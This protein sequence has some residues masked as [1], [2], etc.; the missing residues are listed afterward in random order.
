MEDFNE[1]LARLNK[2][3]TDEM[4]QEMYKSLQDID[5]TRKRC[6]QQKAKIEKLTADI[7]SVQEMIK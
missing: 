1:Y 4:M 3:S 6:E 5:E 2:M 7:R